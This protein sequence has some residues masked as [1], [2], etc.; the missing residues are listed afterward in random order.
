MVNIIIKIPYMIPRVLFQTSLMPQKEYV[1]EMIKKYLGN[2]EYK[3]F[4]DNDII[5]FFNANY[6]SEYPRI[7]ERFNSFKKGQHKSDLFRYYYLYV[8]GGFYM[9]F[10]AMIYKNIDE[11]V[12]EYEFISVNSSV[13][14]QSIFQGLLGAIPKHTIIKQALDNAYYSK[15]SLLVDYHYFCKKMYEF[16]QQNKHGEL[17][18]LREARS[19]NNDEIW[20]DSEIVFKHF[21]KDKV[22]PYKSP[23]IGIYSWINNYISF[24]ENGKMYAFGIGKY[25]IIDKHIVKAD[26]GLK[27]HIITF[28][29]DFTKFTSIRMDG[30]IISGVRNHDFLSQSLFISFST[31]NYARLTNIYFESLNKLGADRNHLLDA[32][33]FEPGGFQSDVWYYAVINKINHLIVSLKKREPYKYFIF[34]D[35]DIS[36]ISKNIDKWNMLEY[37]LLNSSKNLFFMRENDED[38]INSGFFI[39][40]NNQ[41][42]N[43]IAFFEKIH[44]IMKNIKH[45]DMPYGDQTI[46]NKNKHMIDFDYIP[47]KYVIWGKTVFN[48]RYSLFHHAVLCDTIDEKIAQINEINLLFK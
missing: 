20:D 29:S 6:L 23:I 41:L 2:W 31:S 5:Q 7:I 40:K 38:N 27:T 12:K 32:K 1:L 8:C 17:K 34:S 22:I 18:L 28:N 4:N 11:I 43:T 24:S 25:E 3:Y 19:V 26:F 48:S 36:F 13:I 9:D 10:D 39:I 16:V 37:E 21:Y 44:S 47:N 33:E 45:S 35:C 42:D 30:E 46:I 15:N 14:P